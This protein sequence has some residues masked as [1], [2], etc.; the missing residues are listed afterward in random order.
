L[1]TKRLNI[2]HVLY[3]GDATVGSGGVE[4]RPGPSDP[5]R[6]R[7]LGQER[8]AL[9]IAEEDAMF[10]AARDRATTDEERAY[11]GEFIELRQ[12]NLKNSRTA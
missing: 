12:Q 5:C 8:E 6:S 2:A 3:R 10:R 1:I 11:W 7:D 4:D 9:L